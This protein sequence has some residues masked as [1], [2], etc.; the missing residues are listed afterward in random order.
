MSEPQSSTI[1]EAPPLASANA[2][3]KN[4]DTLLV[5]LLGVSLTMNVFLGWKLRQSGMNGG[6]PA[7]AILKEGVEIPSFEAYDITNKPETIAYQGGT[8]VFYVFSASCPWCE[9]NL[10]NIKTLVSLR[11]DSYR[12]V[13]LSLGNSGLESYIDS[14]A[15]NFPVYSKLSKETLQTLKFVS[16]PQTMV[17]SPEGRVL[18]N[19]VGAYGKGLRPEIE[20]FFGVQLPGI[21]SQAGQT[22]NPDASCP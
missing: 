2:I 5:L 19:W 21:T 20:R 8:T 4:W 11:G 9:R 12:F 16:T 10:E 13:G 7:P 14:R 18:K 1:Q 6:L 22:D 3:S 15:L 17:V